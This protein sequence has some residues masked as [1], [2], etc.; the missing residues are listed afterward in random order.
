MGTPSTIPV[1]LSV[2]VVPSETRQLP[3][4]CRRDVAVPDQESTTRL[5]FH[6][7][8]VALISAPG[9][10]IVIEQFA[11]VPEKESVGAG[12]CVPRGSAALAQSA[13]SIT[14]A[15]ANG[16]IRFFIKFTPFLRFY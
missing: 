10:E 2:Y 6:S 11:V 12:T 15:S 3:L 5:P 8:S 13:S 16:I 4:M 7:V 9:L 1:T 14:S